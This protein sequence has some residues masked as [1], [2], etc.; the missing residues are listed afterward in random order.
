MIGERDQIEFV[1]DHNNIIARTSGGFILPLLASLAPVV[2][3]EILKQF[4]PKGS[5][6]GFGAIHLVHKGNSYNVKKT[7]GKGLVQDAMS[8]LVPMMPAGGAP[9]FGGIGFGLQCGEV[10]YPS[11][12]STG[13]GNKKPVKR[14]G[15]TA[16]SVRR[17]RRTKSH[18]AHGGFAVDQNH[19]SAV[20]GFRPH[21]G[22][23][24]FPVNQRGM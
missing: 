6:V 16:H 19:S 23:A 13:F 3:S 5:G 17:P 8:F 7:K 1:D 21:S 15:G 2:L 9:G 20:S 18:I 12:G 14:L 4:H 24:M 10:T 22:T 11:A